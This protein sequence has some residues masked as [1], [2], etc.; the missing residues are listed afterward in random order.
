MLSYTRYP[1][2]D[3]THFVSEGGTSIENWLQTIHS[4]GE[5]G[6]TSRELYDIRGQNNL[7]TN[8]EIEKILAI[9]VKN[10]AIHT[11]DRKTAL[12]VENRAQFGLSRMYELKSEVEGVHT[13]TKVFYR[14]DEA[15]GWLGEDV[16]GCLSDLHTDFKKE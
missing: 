7:F 6:M 8:D 2:L 1:D 11:N 4:Y 10:L 13:K 5:D 3:F 12:V 15:M 14:M 16:A 9:A